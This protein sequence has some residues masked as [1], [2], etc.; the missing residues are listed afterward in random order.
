MVSGVPSENFT[1][2]RIVSSKTVFDESVYFHEVA[3]IGTSLPSSSLRMSVSY[4]GSM[5]WFGPPT[6][7]WAG[8]KVATSDV[9]PMVRVRSGWA[10][11]SV[12]E[13]AEQ[14]AS[15]TARAAAAASRPRGFRWVT[16]SSLKCETWS[17]GPTVLLICQ[18]DIINPVKSG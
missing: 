5:Y 1:P 13:P 3:S 14:P 2:S 11:L 17:V 7:D 16:T 12:P 4:T 8:S 15:A 9:M 18:V 10:D 6:C